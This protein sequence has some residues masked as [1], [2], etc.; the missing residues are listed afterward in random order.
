MWLDVME[1]FF[2]VVY[3]VELSLRFYVFR[4]GGEGG[5]GDSGES[6]KPA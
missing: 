6:V 3:V 2:L 1:W 4:S 5:T